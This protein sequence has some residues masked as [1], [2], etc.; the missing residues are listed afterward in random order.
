MKILRK[1]LLSSLRKPSEQF[2]Q[3]TLLLFIA[4]YKCHLSGFFGG[5]CLFVPS[6]SCYAVEALQTLSLKKACLCIFKRLM[7]CHPLRTN[8]GYDPVERKK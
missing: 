1:N 8:Y 7:R 4:F 6:C 3:R 5:A 2:F